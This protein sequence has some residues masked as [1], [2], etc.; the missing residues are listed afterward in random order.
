MRDEVVFADRKRSQPED[1]PKDEDEIDSDLD[2]D[3]DL[4]PLPAAHSDNEFENMPDNMAT[5]SSPSPPFSSA[6]IV[7]S[8]GQPREPPKKRPRSA[9]KKKRLKRI[10]GGS[11]DI[12]SEEEVAMQRSAAEALDGLDNMDWV[13]VWGGFGCRTWNCAFP[14]SQSFIPNPVAGAPR[15]VRLMQLFE[16]MEFPAEA[17][18]PAGAEPVPGPGPQNSH[19][20]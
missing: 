14:C 5:S 9:G 11:A 1:T 4:A 6:A 13:S 7:S 8:S 17:M 12:D 16:S 2:S 15:S 18:A 10:G 19:Q 3:L 20:A